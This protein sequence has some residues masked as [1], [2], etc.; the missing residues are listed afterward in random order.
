MIR[1]TLQDYM[2][3][4]KYWF[5]LL[6]AYTRTLDELA[7]QAEQASSLTRSD[8]YGVVGFLADRL[9]SALLN[10]EAC[11]IAGI[12][13]FSL[14]VGGTTESL[15][16]HIQP[17]PAQIRVVFRPDAALLKQL[18]TRA[19]FRRVA[20]ARPTP[21]LTVCRDAQTGRR[22]AYVPGGMLTLK[23]FRLDFEDADDL[24]EGVFFVA[25]DGQETRATVYA[26]ATA[27][28]VILQVPQTLSGPQRLLLRCRARAD[29]VD[30]TAWEEML[31][32]VPPAG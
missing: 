8:V 7:E 16:P 17:D 2:E 19:R 9:R 32:E 3:Q 18:R 28:T 27:R 21:N 22:D 29:W 24:E 30:E 25:A 11:Q 1:Y 23:G 6:R 13:T 15:A 5:R 14:A 4:G 20:R 26:Q 12:G 31:Q 10:G